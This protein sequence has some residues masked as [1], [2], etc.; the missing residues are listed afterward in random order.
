MHGAQPLT[1]VSLSAPLLLRAVQYGLKIHTL[2]SRRFGENNTI[3][4]GDHS[5]QTPTTRYSM[6]RLSFDLKTLGPQNIDPLD[7]ATPN[8]YIHTDDH[9]FASSNGYTSHN[10]PNT[11]DTVNYGSA[12]DCGGPGS[13]KGKANIDLSETPFAVRPNQFSVKGSLP[14][15]NAIYSSMDQVVNLTGGGD[16]GECSAN[17]HM[18]QV[19]VRRDMDQ[20]VSSSKHSSSSG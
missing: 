15:G 7:L 19:Y 11:Y 4:P 14:I 1:Y 3:Q 17:N 10:G 5:Y 18:I 9:T 12:G 6:V 2:F 20:A 8:L 16:C 13:A